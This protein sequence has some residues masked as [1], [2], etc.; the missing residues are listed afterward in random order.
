VTGE[1]ASNL[2]LLGWLKYADFLLHVAAPNAPSLGIVLP[3]AISFFTFQQ[4]RCIQT[5]STD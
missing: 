5:F 2:G 4:R 3:L 1:V